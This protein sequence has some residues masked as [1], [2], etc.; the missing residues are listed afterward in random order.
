[1]PGTARDRS[2]PAATARSCRVTTAQPPANPSPAP[3]LWTAP[4][5][6][7]ARRRRVRR[8]SASSSPGSSALLVIAY[9][10]TGARRLHAR[11]RL[12]PRARAARGRAA[13]RALDRPV[14]ARAALGAVVR[15]PL[16]RRPSR[17]RSRSSSTSACSWPSRSPSPAAAPTR[18]CRPSCRRRSSRRRRRASACCCIFAFSRSHFDGPVDGLVYAA[19]AAA[20]FA[21]TENILYF[22][23]ALAEGGAEELGATFV[24]RGIFSP[25]AHVLFTACIGLAIG[26]GARRGG[27]AGVVGWFLLGLVGRGA[28]ARALERLA[29]VRRPTRSGSTSPCRC[30][31]SSARSLL[32]VLP[33]PAG[34]A[35]HAR[36]TRRVRRRRLVQPRRGRDAR[37]TR[38]S[39]AG[40]GRGRGRRRHRARRAMRRLITDATHLAFTRQRTATRA[41]RR[42]RPPSTSSALLTAVAADRA[43]L[44]R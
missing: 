31:S 33:A 18:R 8:R 16:G 15:V 11:H 34:G 26:I 4:P 25:F 24:V 22:G 21:F 37:H 41:R 14:G 9:L 2:E 13:R 40:A 35:H 1:M 30:R 12:G 42:R 27:G 6:G 20:G 19:T 7:A 23:A 44:L 5:R 3:P 32:T 28:A 36:P 29:R 17:S 43:A 38:R 10:A 39:T